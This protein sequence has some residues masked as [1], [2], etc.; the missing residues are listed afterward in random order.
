M[1]G[2]TATPTIKTGNG[3]KLPIKSYDITACPMFM[4]DE[5]QI[6]DKA[7]RCVE[8]GKIYPTGMA[9]ARAMG[10]Q[11]S[12]LNR[13]VNQGYRCSGYHWEKV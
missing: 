11:I 5:G 3:T 4:P 1:E 2:W 8:T 7:V 12:Y 13:A 6:L 9:A 10:C